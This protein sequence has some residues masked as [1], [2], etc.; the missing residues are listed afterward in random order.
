[1]TKPCMEWSETLLQFG[2][3]SCIMRQL[4]TLLIINYSLTL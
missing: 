2:Y 1:V 3:C 4:T